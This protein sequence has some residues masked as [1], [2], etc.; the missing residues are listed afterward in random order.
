MTHPLRKAQRLSL[1]HISAML[2]MAD[3]VSII[4]EGVWDNRFKYIDELIRLGANIT[5]DGK[6]AVIEGVRELTAA[7]VRCTDLRGGA[8][9]IIAGLLATGTTEIEEI[10]HIE[11][12]YED[13]VEKFTALGADIRRVTLPDA[14]LSKAL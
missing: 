4:T 6:V 10:I 2:T 11:R 8:A 5:V 14:P 1:I 9:M 12:G 3:G 7:P 13:V